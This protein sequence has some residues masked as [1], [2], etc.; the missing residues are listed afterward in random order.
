MARSAIC[1]DWNIVAASSFRSPSSANLELG[2]GY[3]QAV[4]RVSRPEQAA[5][6]ALLGAQS[7]VFAGTADTTAD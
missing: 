6:D 2:A 7:K 4:L 1:L 5:I 3:D